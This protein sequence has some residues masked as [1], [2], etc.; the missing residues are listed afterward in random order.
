MPSQIC[1]SYSQKKHLLD[2]WQRNLGLNRAKLATWA[3]SEFKLPH[4]HH[5]ITI[6]HIIKDAS[7]YNTL[8]P[9][10]LETKSKHVV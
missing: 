9:Q 10:E 4:P 2:H 6:G 8:Q 7:K 1:L 5:K 3:A